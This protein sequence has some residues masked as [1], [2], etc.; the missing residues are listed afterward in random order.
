[1]FLIGPQHI[2]TFKVI[3]WNINSVKTKLEKKPVQDLL[4]NYDIISL[5]EVKTGLPV[6][7]PGYV[8][9]KSVVRGSSERGGTVVLI[10]NYLYNS[11]MYVDTSIDE[12]I[13]IQLRC[14]PKYLFGFCYIPPADSQYYSH[15]SF[16][17]IQEKIKTSEMCQRY[18]I[19]GDMNTRF[20]QLARELTE[21]VELPDGDNY[22]YPVLP[23]DIRV[24]NDNAFI[25]SSICKESELVLINNLKTPFKHFVSKKTYKKGSEW[26]SELDTCVASASVVS[27]VDEFSVFHN[28]SLPSDHAPIAITLSLPG[29]DLENLC[30]RAGHLGD[31]AILHNNKKTTVKPI[32]I[33]DVDETLFLN[34]LQL[35]DIPAITASI[36]ETANNVTDLLYQ[37]A[38]DSKRV[39]Q[40]VGNNPAGTHERWDRLV[41][42]K[43]D[44]QLWRAINWKGE[45]DH[46]SKSDICPSD[47]DFKEYFESN[48]NPPN[49]LRLNDCNFSTDV[50][51]PILDEIISPLEIQRQAKL[52]KSDK[53]S[54]PD[55]LSP[56]ILKIL[57]EQWFILL[58]TIFNNIFYSG[59]YPLTWS[60]AKL[61]T[62]FKKGDRRNVR[63]YRGINII[64][65]IAKLYDMVLCSRL[66]QW[67][68]PYR[69]QAGA[70]EKRG[71]LEHIV[72]LR[73][74][75][76][77]ARRKKLTLFV[78]FVDFS[79]AYDRVPRH[80][81][82]RVLQR[83][84]CGSV[85]L[86]AIVA[87]YTVTQSW[88]GTALVLI[89]LG[90]RQGSP[91]S[92]LLFIILV[93]DLIRLIK[94]GCDHDG[95]L[96]WLHVL[97]LMD[98]TVLLSTT[99]R[100]MEVKLT[101]L[102]NYCND[103]G[104]LINQSKTKF[105]VIH[106]NEAD[107]EPLVVNELVVKHCDM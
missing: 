5:N 11:I 62:I 31:H 9:Y 95:F 50:S 88:I 102:Q 106:G 63:N 20:G 68:R 49:G 91:T 1:M 46:S 26:I 2:N 103:Y 47:Q 6:S 70:Q 94:N 24:P 80:T 37:C 76:D 84:G 38:S 22:S 56:G 107:S 35:N 89:T 8:S 39:Q 36:D 69:E 104:M 4:N 16:A 79:Q 12:Q 23:D 77:M 60:R 65:G 67:F 29:I 87:M 90:V 51:I 99:R 78:T 14:A 17:S 45:Y 52:L 42:N 105:F 30:S 97:V 86:C 41:Q 72:S 7:F 61:V 71:C 34:N 57:P 15:D 59:A 83:L 25:L 93:D 53:A 101:L 21:Q 74:L 92:C 43:D 48:F 100:N 85:M 19:I 27:R 28:D 33:H 73:L 18:V 10:K 55:G 96:Q 81:L 44:L 98:D 66:K 13:W 3:S 58:A 82:F 75:C 64:N 32:N 40:V 54:G